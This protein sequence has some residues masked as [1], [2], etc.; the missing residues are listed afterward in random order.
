MPSPLTKFIRGDAI[1][2]DDCGQG[3]GLCVAQDL[4]QKGHE[5]NEHTLRDSGKLAHSLVY[6]GRGKEKNQ[7]VYRKA[8]MERGE[9]HKT[10]VVNRG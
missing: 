1:V 10:T 5:V 6:V 8:K 2:I 3:C 7:G 9:T 4:P